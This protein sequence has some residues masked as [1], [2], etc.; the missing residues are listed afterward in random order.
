VIVDNKSDH[1]GRPHDL[2]L[3]LAQPIRFEV[4]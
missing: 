1:A 2:Q 4:H 3:T